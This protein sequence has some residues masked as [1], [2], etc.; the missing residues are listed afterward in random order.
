M[1]LRGLVLL[2]PLPL[3]SHICTFSCGRWQEGHSLMGS[4]TVVPP[5]LY[6][7]V[8]TGEGRV[9]SYGVR[10]CC[11]PSLPLDSAVFSRFDGDMVLWGR[12]LLCPL[13][14]S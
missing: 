7:L 5:L 9:W 10:H 11:A 13:T 12:V 14:P 1:I 8:L 3:S 4:G 2:C 6:F